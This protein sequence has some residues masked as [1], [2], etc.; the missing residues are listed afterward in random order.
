MVLF[1][2]LIL[3]RILISKKVT[4][5]LFHF[6]IMFL[7]LGGACASAFYAFFSSSM[8]SLVGSVFFSMVSACFNLPVSNDSMPAINC[9]WPFS[10]WMAKSWRKK[11]KLIKIL[12]NLIFIRVKS[13]FL[14][15]QA[16]SINDVCNFLTYSRLI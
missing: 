2:L 15:D 6:M 9:C 5:F 14:L 7:M 13:S 10:C 1:F 4:N 16:S 12:E 8:T 3:S 11:W